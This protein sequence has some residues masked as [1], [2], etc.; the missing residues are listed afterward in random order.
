M[1]A[2]ADLSEYSIALRAGTL[3]VRQYPSLVC[4]DYGSRYERS[5]PISGRA[6]GADDYFTNQL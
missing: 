5:G 6:K 4:S 1:T 2:P 3:L